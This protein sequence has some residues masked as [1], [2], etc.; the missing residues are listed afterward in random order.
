MNQMTPGEQGYLHKLAKRLITLQ[1]FLNSLDV[2]DDLAIDQW[3]EWL[4]QIKEIQGNSNNDISFTACLMA[5]AYLIREFG[6]IDDFDVSAKPQGAP[7]LDIDI[8]TRAG[9][10]IIGEIKTTVPYSGAR[11]DLG[12]QQKDAFQ[13]DFAKLNNT[14]ADYK[15]FFVTDATTYNIVKRKYA[16]Q[17]PGVEI[18]QLVIK[19]YAD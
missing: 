1:N 12:A 16:H 19:D 6:E 10:R 5:K 15:Y 4:A 17:I 7:G 3:F 9:K 11:S 8:Q 18:I 14:P 13:K 2:K